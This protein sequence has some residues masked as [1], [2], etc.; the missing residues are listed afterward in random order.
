MSSKPKL[1]VD[2][3]SGAV[4]HRRKYGGGKNQLIA[5]AVGLRASF[6]PVV[7]DVTAGLGRDGFVLATLGCDVTLCE[8]SFEVYALL[9]EAMTRAAKEAWF[10]ALK[11]KLI[12]ADA[13]DYLKKIDGQ[14]DV[15]YIDPMYPP[16]EKS[17]LPKKEMILL[18]EMVGDDLD[19]ERLFQ[20]ARSVAKKRIVVKRARHAPNIS[21]DEPDLVFE[22][23]SS[24]FDVYLCH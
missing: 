22:G 7:L 9:Q 2:F 18:R 6:K 20:V 23:K 17:A 1:V 5:K 3:L 4:D 13:I 16:K 24:R 21:Q 19:A 11:F 10:S 15:I 12:H 8:R 14:P